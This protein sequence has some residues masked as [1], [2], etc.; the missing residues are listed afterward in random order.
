M[1][2]KV[3]Y[4][5]KKSNIGYEEALTLL[6][7]FDG[8]MT[9][10]LIEL[11]RAGKLKAEESTVPPRPMHDDRWHD[12]KWNDGKW[13]RDYEREWWEKHERRRAHQNETCSRLATVLFRHR[14]VISKDGKD[15][16]NLPT[17]F[18]LMFV[19]LAWPFVLPSVILMFLFGC[20]IRRDKSAGS[21]RQ[22]E[23]HDF[24]NKA[25]EN[26]KTTFSSVTETIQKETAKAS[27]EPDDGG[28][29]TAK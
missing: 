20:K 9:R 29:Y 15:I 1:L 16:I 18:Y 24:V 17:I 27:A 6:E 4:L 7:R 22:D 23:I 21:F 10:I 28:E 8:D 12:G 26:I 14:F 3:E 13:N 11:E 25:S 5:R 19:F 2:E